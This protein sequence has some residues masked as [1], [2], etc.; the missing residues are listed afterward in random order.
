VLEETAASAHQAGTAWRALG[1][2]YLELGRQQEAIEA[3]RKASDLGGATY[4]P[5]RRT[6]VDAASRSGS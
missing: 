3:L 6:S 1:E 5:I 4:N 2:A